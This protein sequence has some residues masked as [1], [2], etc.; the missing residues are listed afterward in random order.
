MTA[1]F[2]FYRGR[3][4]T[5]KGSNY[6]AL[7]YNKPI[8]APITAIETPILHQECVHTSRSPTEDCSP[9]PTSS[10]G[11]TASLQI[12]HKMSTAFHLQTDRQMKRYNA[13]LEAYLWIFCAYEPNSWNKM[14]STAQ[15]AHN[16]RTHETLKQSP[17]QLMYGTT[18]WYYPLCLVKPTRQPLTTTLNPYS[19]P[20]K[21][22]SPH[23]T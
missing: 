13:E 8:T 23:T 18:Q 14:L 6:Y 1:W 7:F 5:Y 12:K 10:K 3:S 20:E 22:Y 19:A 15:F 4:K 2:N 16:S 11:I 21:K 9:H 17:F